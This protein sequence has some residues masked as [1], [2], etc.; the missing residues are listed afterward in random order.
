MPLDFAVDLP[1][2][3]AFAA[4]VWLIRFHPQPQLYAN[5]HDPA[6][7]LSALAGGLEED[8]V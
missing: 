2:G 3:D 7:I 6:L 1:M 8:T 4:P 5:G